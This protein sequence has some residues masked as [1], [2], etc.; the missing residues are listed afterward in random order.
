[1]PP[2]GEG[3]DKLIKQ[4]FNIYMS[5]KRTG[6]GRPAG[7]NPAEVRQALLDAAR[8]QFTERAFKAVSVREIARAAGVNPAMVNYHFGSKRGL[9]EAMVQESVGPLLAAFD[10]D[11]S[12]GQV[13][14]PADVLR[15]HIGTLAANPWLP[16]LV[17]REVLYG[18]TDFRNT[19]VEK[20]SA[21]VAA[22]LMQAIEQQCKSGVL[23]EDLDPRLATLALFSLAV[24]PFLARP[25]VERSLGL[26]INEAFAERWA[27]EAIRLLEPPGNA[28]REKDDA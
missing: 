21:R 5:R 22:N 13:T 26:E 12:R 6:P 8:E 27:Q 17:V 15:R 11:Q 9:Y 3:V 4:T 24:F 10:E 23:R 18:E 2:P 16:N 14:H 20:F 28:K 25:V 19:F 1:M 7:R